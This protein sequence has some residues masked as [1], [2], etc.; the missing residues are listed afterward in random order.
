MSP[1]GR[2][3]KAA[4]I[5]PKLIVYGDVRK[6]VQSGTA[7]TQETTTGGGGC[8]ADLNRRPCAGSDRRI[9]EEIVRVGEHPLG[10]GMYVF[11]YRAEFRDVW[12]HGRQFGAMAD[13]VETVM[14]E[15][16]SQHPEGYKMVDY[17]RLGVTRF[18]S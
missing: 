12:G 16:V 15:A 3:T 14:P 4:Y 6:L 1:E 10:I 13:E 17:A 11:K 2:P 8:S 18:H 7:G 9:K 5:S